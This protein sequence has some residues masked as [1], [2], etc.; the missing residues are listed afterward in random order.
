MN[1][2]DPG[3][4]VNT[5][6]GPQIDALREEF[7]RLWRANG[8][9]R[10]E[11]FL[12]RASNS[13]RAATFHALLQ[14]E[15]RL[16]R[17]RGD[18]IVRADYLS[19]FANYETVVCA[20]CDAADDSRRTIVH[21]SKNPQSGLHVRCPHC[22]NPIQLVPDAKL[23]SINC[24][25]CGSNF[26][27][28]TDDGA[29]RG[30]RA[31][32]AIGHFRL[33]ERLGMGAFGTV[34]KALDTE[35]DRTVA[36]KIPRSGQLDSQHQELF[37]REARS[38]AQLRHPNIVPVYEVGRDGNTLYIVSQYI[39]GIDLSDWLTA[40]RLT[41]REAA[42]LCATIA[43]A[44]HHAHEQGVIHRDLKPANVMID[45]DGQPHIMDF[46]L[47]R[48]D[49][50][51]ITM[52]VEGQVLGTPAYMSPEQAQGLSHM[53]DRRADVYSLGVILFQ[54][55]TGELPFR[56]NSRMLLHQ[57]VH[58]EPPSPKKLNGTVP[59]DLETITLRCLEKDPNRRLPSAQNLT[60][61]LR[62]FL[63]GEPIESRPISSW[64]RAW[65]WCRRKPL[66]A[67]MSATIA[68]L[69]TFVAVAGP[70]VA[71]RQAS[72]RRAAEQ[73]EQRAHTAQLQAEEATKKADSR[74]L[75]SRETV[76][77]WLTGYSEALQNIPVRGVQAVRTRMLELAAEEYETF[78]GE[79]AEDP[80]V[81]LEQGRTLTRLGSIYR[82]L[83]R[84][85]EA[86]A[87]FAAAL[88]VL[89]ELID[90]QQVGQEALPASAMAHG[91][92]A[93]VYADLGDVGR[94]D[95]DFDVAI[96]QLE[97]GLKQR[98]LAPDY[99]LPVVTL[100]TN[101]GGVLAKAGDYEAAEK[102]YIQA[103][104]AGEALV[105]AAPDELPHR[106]AL[107]AARIGAG[108]VQLVAGDA[109]AAS[110][111]LEQAASFF[112]E[113]NATSREAPRYLEL[114]IAANL[115]LAAARR[116]LG[117]AAG[118][119]DAYARA[120]EVVKQLSAAHPDIPAYRMEAAMTL[121]D[122]GQSM[123]EQYE[124]ATAD[125]LLRE[126]IAGLAKLTQEYPA[127]AGYRETLGVALDNLAQ[128]LMALGKFDEG[129]A[130]ADQAIREFQ[131]LATAWPHVTTYRERQA[132]A[133]STAAQILFL[134]GKHTDSG[135]RF[136]SAV[137]ALDQLNAVEQPT[138]DRRQLAA[139]VLS[140]YGDSMYASDPEAAAKLFKRA[141][142]QWDATL[143]A[144]T[145]P[146]F[147]CGAAWFLA[148]CPSDEW[149]DRKRAVDLAAKAFGSASANARYR[150]TL[151]VAQ[152]LAGQGKQSR[153]TSAEDAVKGFAVSPAFGFA[154][155]LAAHGEGQT[156][157][158]RRASDAASE[159]VSS[160]LPGHWE[161]LALRQL[162]AERLATAAAEST[163]S[164]A[165]A[166][167]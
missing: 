20:A 112:S 30:S 87:K 49:M 73:N 159:W 116:R 43:D 60:T 118:E 92:L 115:N 70:L 138:V 28:T 150:L 44:L 74:F 137:E 3:L 117:D 164:K 82:Q 66:V 50:G 21:E 39:R 139:I 35:L 109:A 16:R 119:R 62:R 41:S 10:I 37:L 23:E 15:I 56:G 64:E 47:A 5:N 54:L 108:Q 25:S 81:R 146:Q 141:S 157:D 55:L 89:S 61:E 40:Q 22:H 124:P 129:L 72:L 125:P 65:R 95:K 135:Q 71:L 163:P 42:E 134:A 78:V 57:V 48:R 63:A 145:D 91:T 126:A 114:V 17:Q 98:P 36:I 52:T 86:I 103:L 80:V 85:D 142:Q 51:E 19:R 93:L 130:C 4:T 18:A 152:A 154:R 14:A 94:A 45:G 113:A 29:T 2:D 67:S 140:R 100:W 69:I 151:A 26:S 158:A 149:R 165:D 53:A 110:R 133:E 96:D 144:S 101:R 162:T 77:T 143:E 111:S 11:E 97:G 1:D 166:G 8:A 59:K 127:V 76:D 90:D 104:V 88:E 128:T 105:D 148:T 9:P 46:G 75:K 153:E 32:A 107:A 136:S 13:M 58:D 132:V 160:H 106:A 38:A 84:M 161:M 68:G 31:I 6:D 156:E 123:I 99:L 27:L 24:R 155:A 120:T 33:V 131:S 121:I 79:K 12:S 7:E 83:G 167:P 122:M 102:A 147:A 34:W